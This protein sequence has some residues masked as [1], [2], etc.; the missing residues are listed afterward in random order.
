[1]CPKRNWLFTDSPPRSHRLLTFTEI[2][3][4]TVRLKRRD[5]LPPSNSVWDS[6]CYPSDVLNP[7]HFPV[8]I[9]TGPTIRGDPKFPHTHRPTFPRLSQ[10]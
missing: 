7:I 2:A 4:A 9:S 8:V 10:T 3:I 1:M 6:M 5:D